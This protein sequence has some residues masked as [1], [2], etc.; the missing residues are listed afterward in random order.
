APAAT[1]A[2]SAVGEYRPG[3]GPGGRA[4]DSAATTPA[5]SRRNDAARLTTRPATIAAPV[6]SRCSM[7][8]SNG[9]RTRSTSCDRRGSGPAVSSTSETTRTATGDGAVRSGSTGRA[10][11]AS[12]RSSR[13]AQATGAPTATA[14]ATVTAA[15]RLMARPGRLPTDSSLTDS[16]RQHGAEPQPRRP[17][18]APTVR[19]GRPAEGHGRDRRQRRP[20][21]RS[22]SRQ[23]RGRAGGV[24]RL[25]GR[26]GDDGA[27]ALRTAGVDRCRTGVE[28]RTAGA[29]PQAGLLDDPAELQ[30]QRLG[31]GLGGGVGSEAD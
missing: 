27:R 9:S 20:P 15:H 6:A 5:G 4:P 19:G 12:P 16:L 13:R 2:A 17:A 31:R 7:R 10:R 21:N 26:R 23:R 29:D 22:G 1:A 11:R 3:S 24:G 8:T 28:Y 30:R 14:A 25:A 18:P